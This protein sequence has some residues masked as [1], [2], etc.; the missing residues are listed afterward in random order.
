MLCL[1][2]FALFTPGANENFA[3]LCANLASKI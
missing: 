1:T 3:A 2:L